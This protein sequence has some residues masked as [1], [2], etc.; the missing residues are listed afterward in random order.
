MSYPELRETVEVTIASGASLSDAADLTGGALVG[1]IMPA[2][3]TAASLTFQGSVDDSTYN[4]VYN[5]SGSEY[6]VAAD[7]SRLIVLDPADFV[8]ARHLK[9]RAG[10]SGTPVNQGAARTITLV[11][12]PI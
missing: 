2:A 3:W 12:R 1:I 9:V 4:N 10:T 8:S 11:V 7:A 6:T 5:D